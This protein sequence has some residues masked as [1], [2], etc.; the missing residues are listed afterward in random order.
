MT[1]KEAYHEFCRAEPSISVFMQ[2]FWMDA[3]CGKPNWDVLLHRDGDGKIDAAWPYY[4]IRKGKK[5][6]LFFTETIR[7]M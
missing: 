1:E 6:I 5:T 4:F 7:L 2:A 3:V